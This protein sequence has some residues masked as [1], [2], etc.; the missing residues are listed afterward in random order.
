MIF[1][2][3]GT[4]H[5]P[6]G[7]LVD[8]L[9]TLPASELVV[10]HGHSP[11]PS[12]VREAVAFLRFDEMLERIRAADVVVTHAGVGSILLA[13]QEGHTP[14]VVPRLRRYGEHVDDHQLELTEALARERT[15]VPALDLA[16][17]ATAV[18][19]APRKD[20]PR[21]PSAGPFQ[22]AVRAALIG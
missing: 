21:P 18:A 17:L 5:Q 13:R 22:R 14:V 8:A 4:H 20:A 2:T 3:V 7:R 10:Q 11:A 15:V 1:V 12:G 9:A 19:S 16:A 6:F